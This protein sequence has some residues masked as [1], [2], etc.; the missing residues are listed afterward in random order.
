M[1]ERRRSVWIGSEFEEKGKVGVSAGG[2]CFVLCSRAACGVPEIQRGWRST[3]RDTH[4]HT[5]RTEGQRARF[6]DYGHRRQAKNKLLLH[7]GVQ[8]F[9]RAGRR[10]ATFEGCARTGTRQKARHPHQSGHVAFPS[11]TEAKA[12]ASTH[13][14]QLSS[15]TE[16]NTHTPN[17]SI[18]RCHSSYHHQQHSTVPLNT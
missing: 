11:K 6:Q 3:S 17:H 13:F 15:C 9:Q 4:A 2:L 14:F 16:S 8:H 10:S 12:S 7:R 18:P 5:F 1:V